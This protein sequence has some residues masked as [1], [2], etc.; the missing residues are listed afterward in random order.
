MHN[1]IKN[2]PE[3]PMKWYALC[4]AFFSGLLIHS[5]FYPSLFLLSLL[6]FILPRKEKLLYLFSV[7]CFFIAI[8]YGKPFIHGEE[9][10]YFIPNQKEHYTAK[11]ES[12]RTLADQ[13]WRLVLTDVTKEDET[14]SLPNKT[15]LYIA[16]D[17]EIHSKTPL[18]GMNIGF[19]GSI[20]ASSYP[21]NK[22]ILPGEDYWNKKDIF[23]VSY[24]YSKKTSFSCYG[25]AHYLASVR[26]QLYT[27][28]VDACKVENGVVSQ[29]HA[30]L[31]AILFGERFYFD[32][33]TVDL[34]TKASLVHSIALSGMHLVFAVLCAFAIVKSIAFLFPR[35]I[36][37]DFPLN[38]AVG[39]V[40]ILFALFY[41]WIGNTPISLARAGCMLFIMWLFLISRKKYTLIDCSI[42]TAII[43]LLFMPLSWYD[44]GFQF[45]LLSIFA[46][47]LFSPL[48]RISKEYL[49]EKSGEKS[50]SFSLRILL[51]FLSMLWISFSIQL[52]LLPL[53]VYSFG[54][55]S[56]YFILNAL[57]LPILQFFIL[58]LSFIALFGL[59]I[60]C[61]HEMCIK[62]AALFTQYFLNF[63]QYIESSFSLDMLQIYRFDIWQGIAYYLLILTFIY[64]KK[65]VWKKSLLFLSL[66]CILVHPFYSL[67]DTHKASLEERIE[68]RVL[69]VGQGQSILLEWPKGRALIDGGGVF[70]NRYDTGRDTVAKVLTYQDLPKLDY[71]FVSHFDIDHAK[72]LFHIV[73]HFDIGTFVYSEYDRKEEIRLDLLAETEKKNIIKK[74]V[75]AGDKIVL[76]PNILHIEVLSPSSKEELSSNNASLVLRLVHNNKGIALFCGDIEN[77]GLDELLARDFDLSADL[78]VLP[79]HGSGDAYNPAFYE[80]VKPTQIAVSTGLYNY[81][82]LPS[83][84]VE[85]YFKERNLPFKNTAFEGEIFYTFTKEESNK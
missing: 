33:E 57:W 9:P 37:N 85:E 68:I 5:F 64:W 34:F 7:L 79:H 32:T 35:K 27:S 67:Y 4:F 77:K 25:E 46:I 76:I 10:S 78:L 73:K 51:Y 56:P 75:K 83:K 80:R 66:F 82:N 63:M 11:I 49:I 14:K 60:P 55:I 84:E 72:G 12:V 20:K 19:Y 54:L 48:F 47:A 1:T 40:S 30:L 15:V 52:F 65:I 31:I 81:F 39:F 6:L 18:A 13:R 28:F 29:A 42:L 61:I 23:Y 44:M 8:I 36:L 71:V 45:S 16:Y 74:Q 59:G 38:V 26:N 50:L 24:L 43:L 41:F 21:E 22:G 69:S 2:Y 3:T 17:E 70:G 53:Q 62:Y 58:P